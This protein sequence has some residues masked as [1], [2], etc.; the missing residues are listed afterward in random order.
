MKLNPEHAR[1]GWEYNVKNRIWDPEVN[2][3]FKGLET[4]IK[5][6]AEINQL[7]GPLPSPARYVDQSYLKEALKE[8]GKPRTTD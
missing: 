5:I 8:L 7:K 4:I 6:Y 3:N 1:R 2:L